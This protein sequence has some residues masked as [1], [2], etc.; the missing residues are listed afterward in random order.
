M[1]LGLIIGDQ[2]L[3]CDNRAFPGE[4]QSVLAKR[5]R[6]FNSQ[7]TLAVGIDQIQ[8]KFKPMPAQIERW[9]ATQIGVKLRLV[10]ILVF[11]AVMS[12]RACAQEEPKADHIKHTKC[13]VKHDANF[14]HFTLYYNITYTDGKSPY[15]LAVE[16]NSTDSDSLYDQ[17]GAF[18]K[19]IQVAH[20]E[21]IVA[22]AKAR[23]A[24]MKD[25]NFFLRVHKVADK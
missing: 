4:F 23:M 3:V 18:L 24:K 7:E 13:E 21:T 17:C 14:T 9:M 10:L 6:Q 5:S 8:R 25:E 22:D 20:I 19:A 16:A 1:R 11:C 12:S 2:P 15:H